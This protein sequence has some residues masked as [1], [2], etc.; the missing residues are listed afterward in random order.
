MANLIVLGML[1]AY[2]GYLYFTA[3]PKNEPVKLEHPTPPSGTRLAKMTFLE[4]R[5]RKAEDN[6]YNTAAIHAQRRT[7]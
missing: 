3:R 5:A 2:F 7:A 4:Y 6:K 1:A